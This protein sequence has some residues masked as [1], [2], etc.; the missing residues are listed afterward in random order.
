M[1]GGSWQGN[2]AL[3]MN[4]SSGAHE[5]SY[6]TPDATVDPASWNRVY[7]YAHSLV[8]EKEVAEDL[9]QDAFVVLFREQR[10]GRQVEWVNAWM[11]T[12]V[13]NL[14]YQ[15]SVKERPDLHVPIEEPD[16][17]AGRGRILRDTAADAPSPEQHAIDDEML[18]LSA[19]VLREFPPRERE[20][21][22][23][24]FRGYDFLQIGNALGVSRWTARRNTLKALKAFLVRINR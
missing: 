17:D 1:D 22:L 20:S 5:A 4:S 15:R 11:R 19:R 9:T 10:A 13:K 14:A 23:M 16:E 12:V 3:S 18:R 7:R 8:R 21:I 24:Y 6:G 2:S